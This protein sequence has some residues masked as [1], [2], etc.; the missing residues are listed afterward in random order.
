MFE[1]EGRLSCIASSLNLRL[2]TE[3]HFTEIRDLN[4]NKP[5]ST[6]PSGRPNSEPLE[7]PRRIKDRRTSFGLLER[8]TAFFRKEAIQVL[9]LLR[10]LTPRRMVCNDSSVV[11]SRIF[12]LFVGQASSREVGITARMA[13][14]V[15]RTFGVSG[16]IGSPPNLTEDAAR[17]ATCLQHT[18]ESDGFCYGGQ[19]V[20]EQYKVINCK[21]DGMGSGTDGL[22]RWMDFGVGMHECKGGVASG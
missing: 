16:N 6:S 4:Q 3:I 8:Q 10:S 21:R 12:R 15:H 7:N 19:R 17:R 22:G 2:L 5:R 9:S 11:F 20:P 13:F 1:R 14:L 18:D